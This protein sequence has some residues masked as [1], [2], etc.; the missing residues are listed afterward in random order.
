[1]RETLTL[2]VQPNGD[3]RIAA[4]NLCR[5]WMKEQRE[6]LDDISILHALTE[7]YWVNGS[8]EPFDAD[9]A[10]PFVGLTS[11][12]CIAEDMGY[13]DDG[14]REVLGRL[15]YFPDYMLRSP[16]DELIRRGRVIFKA[17]P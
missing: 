6:K 7:P 16:V 11:A 8:F 10:N 17:A 2:T 13:P 12:P 15:W 4:S 14:K 3:L 1:M 5:S 9:Q